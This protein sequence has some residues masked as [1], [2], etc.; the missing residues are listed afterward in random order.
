MKHSRANN[1]VGMLFALVHDC[2]C[3]ADRISW[4]TVYQLSAEQGVLALVWDEVERLQ[5]EG[6]IAPEQ[7]PDKA[8]KLQWALRAKKIKHRYHQQRQW[9]AELAEAFAA[10]GVR[11]NVLKGLSISGYYPVPELR[12]CGD[13][14]CFLSATAPDG[15]FVCQYDEGNEILSVKTDE[16]LLNRFREQKAL[17]E[18]ANKYEKQYEERYKKYVEVVE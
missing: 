9:A 1:A 16:V 13:L 14:D 15:S 5:R 17:M 11:T 2:N 4:S 12:E 10:R 18:I 6:V 7:M 8:L 3:V